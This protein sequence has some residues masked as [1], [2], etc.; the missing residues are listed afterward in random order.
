[1]SIALIKI[2]PASG[3]D[4]SFADHLL[5]QLGAGVTWPYHVYVSVLQGNLTVIAQPR[6]AQQE[7][8]SRQLRQW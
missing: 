6:Q 8:C 2:S 1:M 4:R 3:E 7:G 5:G